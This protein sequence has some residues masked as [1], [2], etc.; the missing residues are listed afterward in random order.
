M[1]GLLSRL[2][3][4][5]LVLC[6][7]ASLRAP[8]AKPLD[9]YEYLA[10]GNSITR[11][12]ESEYWWNDIGMAASEESKDYFH[13]VAAFLREQYGE[14]RAAAVNFV[15][16]ETS[17]SAERPETYALI[18]PYLTD[19][20]DLITLQLSENASYSRRFARDYEALLRHIQEKCP[21]ATVIA[22]DDFWNDK[23]A[24]AKKKA[25]KKQQVPFADLSA[26]RGDS[27]YQQAVGGTVY[28]ADGTAHVIEN[29]DVAR[30]PNDDGM[31]YIARQIIDLLQTH[32][33]YSVKPPSTTRVW[34]V[35]K[36]A[37][38]LSRKSAASATSCA[39][40]RRP[41]GVSSAR[42]RL[43]SPV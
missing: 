30:H 12:G 13:I 35:I 7:L 1:N 2:I 31:D 40:H 11:H 36:E 34:P 41:R 22:V 17:D 3:P 29:K 42:A 20:L 8:G 5:L 15:E 43:S 26:I 23:K 9:A 21:Q 10:I 28:G 33:D 39:V 25:A 4:V 19:S 18:D 32:A 6:G 14:V 27:A 16:W 38:S 24:A 37:R